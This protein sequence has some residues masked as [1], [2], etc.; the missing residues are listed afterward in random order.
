MRGANEI[1]RA[2]ERVGARV[3]FTVWAARSSKMSAFCHRPWL[4]SGR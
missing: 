1:A 4:L 3:V 2:L